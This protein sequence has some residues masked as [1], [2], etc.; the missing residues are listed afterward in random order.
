VCVLQ[1]L[2]FPSCLH[3]QALVLILRCFSAGCTRMSTP[4][5]NPPQP[6]LNESLTPHSGRPIRPRNNRD[7]SNVSFLEIHSSNNHWSRDEQFKNKQPDE[8]SSLV[9]SASTD[10]RTIRRSSS[11]A[12]CSYYTTID[13]ELEPDSADDLN[14]HLNAC[15]VNHRT[16]QG[17][18]MGSFKVADWMST[19]SPSVSSS[20]PPGHSR[21]PSYMSGLSITA[22][23]E[24]RSM[25]RRWKKSYDAEF[26]EELVRQ[27][28][29]GIRVWYESYCTIDWLHELIKESVRRKKLAQLSGLFGILSRTWDRSQA[30]VLVTL[31]GICTAF[32]ADRIV[33]AEMWLEDFKEGLSILITPQINHLGWYILTFRKS[34]THICLVHGLKH[35]SGI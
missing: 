14:R 35:P 5:G 30:W 16:S 3:P 25:P 1:I 31:V 7:S 22:E 24:R 6:N 18:L 26:Q 29:N 19:R 27:S 12:P 17:R 4:P 28:G 13:Q 21:R 33:S 15:P 34:Q 8:R 10:S 20:P 2:L 32:V 11:Q 23:T 9:P